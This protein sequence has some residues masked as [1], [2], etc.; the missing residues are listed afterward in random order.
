M[1]ILGVIKL[2]GGVALFLFGMTEMSNGLEKA[3][4]GKLEKTLEK[5]TSNIFK[6]VLLGAVVTAAIQ[7]SSATTV[8]VVGLVNAGIMKLSQAVGVIMG[9]NIGTTITAQ[10][11]RLAD[12]EGGNIFL[13][14]L[15]PTTLAPLVSLVG[16][17]LFMISK[18]SKYKNIGQICLGFGVLFSGMFAMEAAVNPLKDSPVFVDILSSLSNPILGIIAGAL[19]TALI[20][21][22]S[23]SIGILQAISATGV[24]KF[25]AAFPIIMGQ[26]IGT[27]ITPVLAC[28]GANKNAKKSAAIHLSFNIIGTVIFLIATY[29]IEYTIGLPGWDDNIGRSG[30]A[31]FHTIFNVVNTFLL[32]PFNKGLVWIADH[33]VDKFSKPDDTISVEVEI[34]DERLLRSPSLAI[35]QAS[36]TVEKMAEYAKINFQA[37]G[38]LLNGFDKKKF[39]QIRELEDVID[40]MEDRLG[41]YLLKLS[42]KE[43]SEKESRHVT[44]LLHLIGEF[45]RIGDY[46][47]N[48][49][50][51]AEK[52][53]ERGHNFSD[54]AKVELEAI[55]EAVTEILGLTIKCYKTNSIKVATSIEPLEETIDLMEETLK[56]RHIERLKDGRCNIDAGLAFIDILTS[57]ERIGDHC[58]NIAV[59]IIADQ[60]PTSENF[61]RHEYKRLVHAGNGRDFRELMNKYQKLYFSKINS[62]N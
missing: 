10:I 30:I 12:I 9:A 6:A 7:S 5:L 31:N 58:S 15:K 40:K 28:I 56:D 43:L 39:D 19:V 46:S 8:I 23:A 51:Q 11:I 60:K 52:L 57:I 45:E 49:A 20:Q 4:G 32:L 47:M 27:C 26:N 17:L 22:S 25:S 44:N 3:S 55:C 21:S 2:L 14:L 62:E 50:E 33:V 34:L 1:D 36:K 54:T 37:A 41:N 13:S 35:E 16:I 48:L 38:T 53:Y 61:D 24:L 29:T 59:Y 18:K 42:D